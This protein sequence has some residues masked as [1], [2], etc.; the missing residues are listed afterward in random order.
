MSKILN[1]KQMTEEDIKL[2]YITPSI[3]SKWN[4]DKITMETQ[5][6]DGKITDFSF[7]STIINSYSFK[8]YLFRIYY[9]CLDYRFCINIV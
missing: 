5:I 9:F 3:I 1:K 6:T 7:F 4:K 8:Y 2:H